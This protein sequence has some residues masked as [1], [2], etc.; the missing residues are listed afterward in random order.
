MYQN[1]PFRRQESVE[2]I[3]QTARS[4]KSWHEGTRNVM[5]EYYKTR[6]IRVA[7]KNVLK[8]DDAIQELRKIFN[9]E[10]R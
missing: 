8:R 4:D 6:I 1:F 10:Y 2:S 3:L 5:Y 7:G 9:K